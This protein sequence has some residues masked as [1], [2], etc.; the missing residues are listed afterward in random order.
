MDLA[1]RGFCMAVCL[2]PALMPP[3]PW[4]KALRRRRPAGPPRHRGPWSADGT[5]LGLV[6][7]DRS[8]GRGSGPRPGPEARLPRLGRGRRSRKPFPSRRMEPVPNAPMEP[9]EGTETP[10]PRRRAG[11]LTGPRVGGFASRHGS[12]GPSG[13][14]P[15]NGGTGI[16]HVRVPH[17]QGVHPLRGGA[18]GQWLL[19]ARRP[20]RSASPPCA[21]TPV[22]YGHNGARRMQLIEA[23]LLA[24]G[25]A[26]PPRCAC[27]WDPA[28]RFSPPAPGGGGDARPAPGFLDRLWSGRIRGVLAPV[29]HQARPI[30]R[31][32]GTAGGAVASFPPSC[33]RTRFPL[34]E[35]PTFRRPG[36]GGGAQR[37]AAVTRWVLP[38]VSRKLVTGCPGAPRRCAPSGPILNVYA[39]R[40]RGRGG[41]PF[42]ADYL[43]VRLPPG[44]SGGSPAP[45][46]CS[47]ACARSQPRTGTRTIGESRLP[48]NKEPGRLGRFVFP[49][50]AGGR[51]LSR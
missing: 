48:A 36:A 18:L 27:G 6:A 15:P 11:H 46:R 21:R 20:P 22:C 23:A 25:R 4:P 2:A 26:R 35:R 39:I 32:P 24:R 41:G 38:Q 47:S 45:P 51:A 16:L 30:R 3:R 34:P 28:R 14:D 5:F 10:L 37:H 1:P 31:G 43:P 7:E 40:N 29:G 50:L 8:P 13:G 33:C 42:A 44:P 17:R 19:K 49:R 12:I 9:L